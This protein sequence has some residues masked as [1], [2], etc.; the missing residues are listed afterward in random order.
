MLL[1]FLR[2]SVLS[3]ALLACVT[4]GACGEDA[5]DGPGPD[6]SARRGSAPGAV[7]RERAAEV[8]REQDRVA[9]ARRTPPPPD[10]YANPEAF[11]KKE[12]A[13][14]AAAAKEEKPRDYPAELLAAMRGTE[15]CVKPRTAAE[16]LPSELLISLEG[17]VLE[18]G[19]VVSGTARA[20][21]L[22]PEEIECV[23]RRLQS[24]R[25]PSDVKEA[26][27]RVNATLKLTFKKEA[28][29]ANTGG[30]PAAAPAPAPKPQ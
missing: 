7:T 2:S 15:S 17:L 14:E 24:S 16:S 8:A 6:N 26:P 22:T 27:R 19:T 5:P 18:S 21:L 1:S 29:A 12:E 30:A 23:K 28:P 4:L 10:P 3:S 9:Q 13:P 11:A 25:L 20:P